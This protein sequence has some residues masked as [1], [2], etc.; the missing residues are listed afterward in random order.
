MK[1]DFDRLV[2]EVLADYSRV[3]PAAGA[4]EAWMA[5]RAQPPVRSRFL[6]LPAMAWAAVAL[7]L[8][9]LLGLSWYRAGG[10]WELGGMHQP[11]LANEHTSVHAVA[12]DV[13]LTPEQQQLIQLLLTDPSA[14]GK[15]NSPADLRKLEA[16][17]HKPATA[18]QP[19]H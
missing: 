1:P 18:G 2:D 7:A 4:L 3:E 11:T 12:P 17:Q 5:R 6:G 19:H 10:V 13:P 15:I 14:L 16:A 8:L 9:V